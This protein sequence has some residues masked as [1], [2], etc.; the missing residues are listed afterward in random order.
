MIRQNKTVLVTG[1]GEGLGREC[2]TSARRDGANVVPAARTRASLDDIAAYL[3]PTG[4][5]LAT[6]V[7]DI[8]DPGS[9]ASLVDM[10]QRRFSSVYA[11]I[12]VAA[13]EHA[14]G[15]L[16]DLKFEDWRTEFD[17]NV[18]GTHTVIRPVAQAG[19]KAVAGLS[20]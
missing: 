17:T 16:Y 10:A 4:E 12:Q 14:W 18:I 20:C 11:L 6:H 3:D 15:G 5:R 7:T 8:T 19:R 1:V 13:L 2:A 9:C